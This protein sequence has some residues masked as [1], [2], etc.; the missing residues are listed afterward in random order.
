MIHLFAD[1]LSLIRRIRIPDTPSLLILGIRSAFNP[2]PSLS[3]NLRPSLS[4]LEAQHHT[5]KT[6]PSLP[7]LRFHDP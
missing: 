6:T 5:S 1:S 7:R 2:G 3:S 4:R